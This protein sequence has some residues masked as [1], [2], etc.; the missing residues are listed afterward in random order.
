MP[1]LDLGDIQLHYKDR[2]EGPPV[3]GIMGFAVDQRFWAAQVSAMTAAH[4]FITFDN[5]GVGK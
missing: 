4:R 5:R 1:M 2:G 3:L